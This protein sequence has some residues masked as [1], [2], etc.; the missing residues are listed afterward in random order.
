MGAKDRARN[1]AEA[2]YK[3][4]PVNETGDAG[5]PGVAKAPVLLHRA[6]VGPVQRHGPGGGAQGW[7]LVALFF[8]Q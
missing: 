2:L 4:A 7:E 1:R 8:N 6:C 3:H 5:L